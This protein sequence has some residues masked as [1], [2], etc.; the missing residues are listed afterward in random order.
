M[1]NTNISIIP[2]F[3]SQVSILNLNEYFKVKQR[4]DREFKW[5]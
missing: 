2:Q 1:S 3:L 5:K 4:I